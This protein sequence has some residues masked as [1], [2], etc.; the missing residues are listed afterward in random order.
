HAHLVMFGVFSFWIFG[1]IEHLWPKLT[2]HNWRSE[3]LRRWSFWLTAL[4][5]WS[6]FLTLT[7]GGLIEGFMSMNLVARESILGTM[8][9][10]WLVR[11]IAG[12]SIIVGFTCLVTNM[13]LTARA[14]RVAHVDT[15]YSP[16]EN[17]EQGEVA[18]GAV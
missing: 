18:I 5:L 13:Y 10:F 2:G 9:P 4:G 16:Y 11:T 8:G 3:G 15:D 7:A 14:G 6:M 12:V 17:A 1:M